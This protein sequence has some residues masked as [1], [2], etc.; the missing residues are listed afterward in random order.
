MNNEFLAYNIKKICRQKGYS[1]SFLESQLSM[2]AGLVSRWS[3]GA[4]SPSLEKV[5]EIA[6]F[7]DTNIDTLVNGDFNLASNESNNP[8]VQFEA[9]DIDDNLDNT[10]TNDIS[11]RLQESSK[12]TNLSDF[13]LEQE[14]DIYDVPSNEIPSLTDLVSN[15]KYA[16]VQSY[17][18]SVEMNKFEYDCDG[19]I[20]RE[21]KRMVDYYLIC[22]YKNSQLKTSLY[23]KQQKNKP[24]KIP[25]SP[26]TL[27]RLLNQVQDQTAESLSEIDA[28][29]LLEDNNIVI[30]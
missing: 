15:I 1:M 2:S 13:L 6:K 9:N 24:Y 30:A 20:I 28:L 25:F 7:L 11:Y 18:T 21:Y 16:D 22:Y 5:Y 19:N 12:K 17:V 26:T 3:K 14:W 29:N 8:I 4:S 23:L 10:N 27:K